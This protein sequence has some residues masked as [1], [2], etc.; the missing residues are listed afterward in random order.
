M[1]STSGAGAAASS[2][3]IGIRNRDFMEKILTG[4]EELGRA[5]SG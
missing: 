4:M 3:A 2:R 1:I 5:G